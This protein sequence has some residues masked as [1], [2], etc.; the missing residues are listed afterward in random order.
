MFN[1]VWFSRHAPTEEQL[2]EIEEMC[3]QLIDIPS[4]MGLGSRS[5]NS[6]NDLAD[7]VKSIRVLVERGGARAIF[8]V[9][10]APLQWM[11]VEGVYYSHVGNNLVTDGVGC[12]ASWNVSRMVEGGK[13]SFTHKRFVSVGTFTSQLKL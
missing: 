1:A 3:Y 6:D 10:P 8:G 2:A 11:L 5:I 12:Y 7:M 9:F 4:G 13:P